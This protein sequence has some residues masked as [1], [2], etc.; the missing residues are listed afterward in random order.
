M[1]S[2]TTNKSKAQQVC[3]TMSQEL[4][5]QHSQL[6][7]IISP[8][9]IPRQPCNSSYPIR[10]CSPKLT[11]TRVVWLCHP[12]PKDLASLGISSKP[13]ISSFLIMRNSRLAGRKL[14]VE[15]ITAIMRVTRTSRRWRTGAW[16]YIMNTIYYNGYNCDI[17]D[18]KQ[19]KV[20][21]LS[22]AL[23]RMNI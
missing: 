7:Y 8:E 17:G 9:P 4:T 19:N 10:A 5:I 12:P 11:Q 3:V 6:W 22:M 23:I 13:T 15:I 1:R 16:A 18:S 2:P 14:H 21:L 20:L